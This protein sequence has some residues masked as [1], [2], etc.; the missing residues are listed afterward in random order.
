MNF[1]FFVNVA[2]PR[3]TRGS[4]KGIKLQQVWQANKGRPLRIE[5]NWRE[6][7]IAPIGNNSELVS[8]FVS[9][10]IK[11]TVPPY[12]KDWDEVPAHFKEQLLNVVEV[13]KLNM[14]HL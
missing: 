2:Q 13:L 12:Y 10:H 5:F 6:G 3:K 14:M 7:T 4:A 8:R 9:S 1:F 11:Q